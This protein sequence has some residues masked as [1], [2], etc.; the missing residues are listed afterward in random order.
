MEN[1]GAIL[2]G[3]SLH[4][5]INSPSATPSRAPWLSEML[6]LWNKVESATID[7]NAWHGICQIKEETEKHGSLM[8]F[9]QSDHAALRTLITV[10]VNGKKLAL[11][12]KWSI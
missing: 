6:G 12:V 1:W 10:G 5:H 2:R 8:R 9:G 7:C 3:T 11:M 4:R